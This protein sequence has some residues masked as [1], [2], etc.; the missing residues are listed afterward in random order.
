[1]G[2]DARVIVPDTP[3]AAAHLADAEAECRALEARWTRFDPTSELMLLNAAGGRPVRVSPETFAVI[4]RAV[5]AW[6]V[7]GGRFDPT[8]QAALV[9]LGYDRD[10]RSLVGSGAGSA[11]APATPLAGCAEIVLDPLVGAVTLPAGVTLDLGGIGKGYAADVVL[12]SLVDRG[13]TGACVDLGG[14]VR[15]GGTGPYDGA[16]EVVFAEP[17][18]RAAFGRVRLGDGAVATSTTRRRR[19]RA[20][21]ADRHHLL[22]PATGAPSASGIATA[23]V[24][25]SDAWWAEVLAKAALIAGRADGLALL[26]AHGVDGVL[27]ADDGTCHPTTGFGRWCVPGD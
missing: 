16:W 24:V 7:T 1:M 21:G 19:W 20:G 26:A 3:A 5:D 15:V 9:A 13:V 25:A 17:A 4:A 18:A 11:P 14:D 12:G 27:L 10:F 23:T 6:R 22:D 8:G 2:T